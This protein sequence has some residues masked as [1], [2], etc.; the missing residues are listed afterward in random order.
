MIL[1]IDNFDSFAHNL[2]R[3]FVRLGEPVHV[4][5]NDAATVEQ[6]RRWQPRAIVLSP[7]PCTPNEAGCSLDVVRA[8]WNE[9]PILGVCLGHQTIVAALGGTIVRSPL[10]DARAD[11]RHVHDGSAVFP[12]VPSPFTACRY[13]SLIADTPRCRLC[14]PS[15][16]RRATD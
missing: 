12:G 7:G 14:W 11:Q 8:C 3:Y 15:A 13:H 9:F 5:R 10:P 4:V 2:A 6:I 1:L 16:G